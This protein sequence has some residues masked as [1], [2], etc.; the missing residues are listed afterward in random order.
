MNESQE[1]FARPADEDDVEGHQHK[2]ADGESAEDDVEGHQHK[3][4]DGESAE[5]DVEGHQHRH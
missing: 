1:P 5:D 2:W 3:W 4:A